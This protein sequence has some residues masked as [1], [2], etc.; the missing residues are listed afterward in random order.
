MNIKISNLPFA[1]SED[2]FRVENGGFYRRWFSMIDDLDLLKKTVSMV[3]ETY[4]DIWVPIWKK[5]GLVFEKLGDDYA[6]KGNILL[7]KKKYLQA[8]TYYS[9]G[10]FPEIFSEFK[11]DIHQDCIRAFKKAVQW[12]DPPVQSVKI[13]YFKFSSQ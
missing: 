6:A 10:R 1:P 9:I 2:P 12:N 7:A 3:S 4:E 8:K 11:K 5:N 13:K